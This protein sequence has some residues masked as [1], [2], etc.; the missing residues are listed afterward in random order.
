MSTPHYAVTNQ[1]PS[2]KNICLFGAV[3]HALLN[4]N[5]LKK[6]KTNK[7]FDSRTIIGFYAGHSRHYHGGVRLWCPGH[8][9]YII[10]HTIKIDESRTYRSLQ[11]PTS[12]LCTDLPPLGNSQPE[13]DSTVTLPSLFT[14]PP[15]GTPN[16]GMAT[17]LQPTDCRGS[18]AD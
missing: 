10:A 5:Q 11:C 9:S 12:I 4:P 2:L 7:R 16:N 14:S 8:P 1:K 17:P 18:Y 13:N 6:D 15:A 3:T